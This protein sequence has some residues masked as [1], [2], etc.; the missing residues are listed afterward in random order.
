MEKTYTKEV[1][2]MDYFDLGV[3]LDQVGASLE[4]TIDA[5]ESEIDGVSKVLATVDRA[6]YVSH[7]KTLFPALY[8]VLRNIHN[9]KDECDALEERRYI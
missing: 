9:L 7:I 6:G 4:L 2:Y 3:C 1:Q 5:L 8:M